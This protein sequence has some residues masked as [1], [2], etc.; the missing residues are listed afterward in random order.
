VGGGGWGVYMRWDMIA[1]LYTLYYLSQVDM[2][3]GHCNLS[4][5]FILLNFY[6]LVV[7][8][9]LHTTAM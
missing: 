4:D 1:W 3:R 9:L 7:R 2:I 8:E 6:A 5:M